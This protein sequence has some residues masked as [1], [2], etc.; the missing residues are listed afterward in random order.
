MSTVTSVS[1]NRTCHSPLQQPAGGVSSSGKSEIKWVFKGVYLAKGQCVVVVE[2]STLRD[3]GSCRVDGSG[4]V[5]P[6][7]PDGSYCELFLQ[8]GDMNKWAVKVATE[9][10]RKRGEGIVF[11]AGSGL[12]GSGVQAGQ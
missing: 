9:Q 8:S 2:A 4:G 7:G 12:I 11:Q 1:V 10:D 6:D 5:F 3:A